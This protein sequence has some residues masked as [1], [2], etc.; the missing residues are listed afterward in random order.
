MSSSNS[1]LDVLAAA[2]G[3]IPETVLIH[4]SGVDE[5]HRTIWVCGEIDGDLADLTAQFFHVIGTAPATM[6]INS[7][8]GDVSA[9]FAIY[10]I[11]RMP[12]RNICTIGFG[13]VASAAV[14]LLAAGHKRMVTENVVV[15][16]HEPSFSAE[17]GETVGLR[18]ARERR[19][20]EDWTHA[21]WAE[22]MARH[23]RQEPAWWRRITERK[24]EYW[25]LGG[26]AVVEAGLADE[27]IR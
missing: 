14:L 2:T 8:G 24:A 25:L 23:T 11:M 7:P 20:W 10:D 9:M 1:N 16:S 19:K 27:V 12:G 4:H 22:L 6:W 13:E 17:E 3:R 26:D 18:A 21:R 5:Q 15:M